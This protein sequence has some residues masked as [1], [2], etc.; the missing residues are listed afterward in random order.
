MTIERLCKRVTDFGFSLLEAELAIDAQAHKVIEISETQKSIIRA[1][2]SDVSLVSSI[3][4]KLSDYISLVEARDY[5]YLMKDGGI[6][7]IAF[8]YNG[9]EVEKHRLVFYPCP[10]SITLEELEKFNGGLSEFIEENFM[11]ALDEYVLS[12]SPI[13]F[14]YDP[15]SGK[16]FHPASHITFNDRNCR[17]PAH[18][19]LYF[20][21]FIKFVFEN[22]YLDAWTHPVTAPAL[23]FTQEKPCLSEHDSSRAYLHW[24]YR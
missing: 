21:T 17:I 3:P 2:D 15:E 7:Q 4:S 24:E 20:D 1:R 23:S 18:A 11:D 6:I 14:D 12:R 13:R 19:P 9:N 5:S 22:F 16:E 10:F 8:T